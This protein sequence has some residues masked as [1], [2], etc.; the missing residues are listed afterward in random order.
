[1]KK[2]IDILKK[3]DIRA[4]DGRY[5]DGFVDIDDLLYL[6]SKGKAESYTEKGFTFIRLKKETPDLLK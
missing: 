5:S 2:I 6:V 3:E 1:M 4:I